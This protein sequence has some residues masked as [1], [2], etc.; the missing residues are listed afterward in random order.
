MNVVEETRDDETPASNNGI[1]CNNG[2]GIG[3]NGRGINV[4]KVRHVLMGSVLL[5]LSNVYGGGHAS[6]AILLLPSVF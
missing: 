6:D 2:L 1:N 5:T 3:N 4:R